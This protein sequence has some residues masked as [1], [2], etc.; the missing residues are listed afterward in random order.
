MHLDARY[1]DDHSVIEGDICI[2]GAGAAGISIAL[3]WENMP[4]KIILLEGGDFEYDDR[5]QELYKGKS[6]GQPYYP[7]KSTRLHFFGG[8][9]GH[10]GGLCSTFEPTSF[11]KRDWVNDSGWPF[12]AQEMDPFYRRAHERLQLGEYNFS[13]DYWLKK[14]PSLA[15]L[16]LDKSVFYNKIW[17]YCVPE[18]MK[19]GKQF[20]DRI[21][22]SRHIQ[23]Y[24][25]ANVVDIQASD[26][27]RMVKELT[28]KNYTGKTHTVRARYFVLACC[29]IQNA[30]LLLASSSQVS[31]GIGNEYDHV[32]R[33]FME[34]IE[35][36][37]AELWLTSPN[38]LQF[39]MRNSPNFRAELGISPG[40]QRDLQLLNGM[41][42]FNPLATARKTPAFIESWT[43]EDPRKNRKKMDK[44]YSDAQESRISRMFESGKYD[45]FEI[46]MRLEQAPNPLS[47]VTLE[48]NEKDALGVPR[49][50]LHWAFTQMEKK[51]ASTLYQL[52][53]KQVGM[54]G[55]GRVKI[56]EGLVDEKNTAMPTTTSGGWHHMGTTRMSSD[57]KK[58][59]VNA[60]CRI[61]SMANLFV[62]GSSCFPNG[63]A[64][65][66]TFSIVALSIRLADHLKNL[67]QHERPTE[68]V[69]GV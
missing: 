66:P 41:L 58:G 50:H 48:P 34:N 20:K 33:Y 37:S 25:Y 53:G 49:A 43:D 32:G 11:E 3:E 26:N 68:I 60:D 55:V 62:A 15:P 31:T 65:N 21:V 16:P 42:S 40:K 39:Y 54:A 67:V 28:V 19:F 44:I 46:T 1:L 61:H 13:T 64:V 8:T 9:T 22:Q 36:K 59:V 5:V 12:P 10:W 2:V 69:K 52:L 6:T 7:L 17:R 14:N 18:A 63:A 51:T 35:I 45:S 57:P 30:R 47:R 29:A 38:A 23:L 56:E 4:Y 27:V 24:T